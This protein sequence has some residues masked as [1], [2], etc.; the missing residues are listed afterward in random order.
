MQRMGVASGIGARRV[1]RALRDNSSTPRRQLET[2]DRK[3]ALRLMR[4]HTPPNRLISRHTRA[5]LRRYFKEGKLTTPIADRLV[6]DRIIDMTPDERCVYDVVEDYISTTYNQASV[7]QRNPIDF[8]MTIHRRRLA[9]SF[10]ALGRTLEKY[11]QLIANPSSAGSQVDLEEGL[12]GL[13]EGGDP[14]AH[15]A[16]QLKQ[17]ALALKEKSDIDG[18]LTMIRRLPPDTKAER[19]RHTIG[20]LRAGGYGQVMVITQFTDTRNFLR[21]KI[22]RDP[23]LRIMCFSGRSDEP[24]PRP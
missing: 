2:A 13:G 15:E 23:G 22:G 5:L 8:V 21:V 9:S 20:E 24:A 14:D 6:E 19:L 18:L 7:P 17:T 11:L 10:F 1:L 4:L 3:S 16:A 12:D